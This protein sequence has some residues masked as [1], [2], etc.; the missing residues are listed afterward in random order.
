MSESNTGVAAKP[1]QFIRPGVIRQGAQ[2]SRFSELIENFFV[3]H[4]DKLVRLHAAMFV[5]FVAVIAVPLFLPD[6]PETAT[7]WT[8][9]TTFANWLLWG[10]WFPLVFLLE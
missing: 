8:H 5:L 6:P 10:V 7:Q 1:I 9:Y 3:R 2:T 4:R